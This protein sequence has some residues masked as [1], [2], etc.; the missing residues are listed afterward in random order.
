MESRQLMRSWPRGSVWFPVPPANFPKPNGF[1]KSLWTRSGGAG[2]AFGCAIPWRYAPGVLRRPKSTW[3]FRLAPQRWRSL[4]RAIRETP[5]DVAV[6]ARV[7]FS[8]GGHD[9]RPTYRRLLRTPEGRALAE[10]HGDYPSVFTDYARLRELPDGTLG[11]EY[12]RQLDERGI[13]P[14]EI[15]KATMPAYEGIEFSSDHAWV[16]DRQRDMHDLLHALTDY[17][18]DMNGEGGLAAFTF[19]QTG[20]KGWAMLALLNALTGLSTGRFDGLVVI[21][22]AYLRGRRA[23]YILAE[24]DWERLFSTPIED[25]RAELRIPPLA[26]YRPMELGEAFV[27]A[28]DEAA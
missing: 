28:R 21:A 17:G 1:L 9:E 26:P 24:N 20:N 23:R 8:I 18:I 19:A 22:K 3:G 11:R 27:S 6:G 13:H 2:H 16:R 15:T 5:D 25:V 4:A 10:S 7:F 12:V 14:G